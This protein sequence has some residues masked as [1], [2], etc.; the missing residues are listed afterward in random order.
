MGKRNKAGSELVAKNYIL[1]KIV[2]KLQKALRRNL[3]YIISSGSVGSGILIPDWSDIDFIVVTRNMT[4]NNK[5]IIARTLQEIQRKYKVKLGGLAIP[6]KELE[7]PE[8]PLVSLDGKVLQTILELS[9]GKQVVAF[10]KKPLTCFRPDKT[11]VRKWSL[12]S[13]GQILWLHRRNI[14][15][16]DFYKKRVLR[17]QI[18]QSLHYALNITKLAI[19]LLKG[20]TCYS[21]EQL[22]GYAG[23]VFPT[24]LIK[25]LKKII[26]YKNNWPNSIRI[27]N[28][29][30]ILNI[31]DSY[32]EK[33]SNYVFKK[34]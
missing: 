33:C 25:D 5:L 30:K 16:N 18:K 22:L 3:V 15:R 26:S 23:K 9:K 19:Q 8:A 28:R 11:Q 21:D 13:I 34:V 6:I 20:R 4:L 12:N 17:D 31:I 1:E 27:K 24:Y 14:L 7:S 32:I 2:A 10:G 29:L